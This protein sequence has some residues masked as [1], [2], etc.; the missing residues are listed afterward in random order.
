VAVG[1]PGREQEEVDAAGGRD[2]LVIARGLVRVGEPD[3]LLAQAER[4]RQLLARAPTSHQ[5]VAVPATGVQVLHPVL[6]VRRR[7]FLAH[8]LPK[9]SFNRRE[10]GIHELRGR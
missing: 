4:R 3:L 10:R 6:R 1:C 8:R 7:E 5:Q 2:P 9:E